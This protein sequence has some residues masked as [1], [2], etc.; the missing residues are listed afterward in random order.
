MALIQ[1]KNL[2]FG[3]EG[4]PEWVFDQASFQLDTNW[5]T[6]L[7]G[8]NGR[9]KTTPFTPVIRGVPP[10]RGDFLSSPNGILSFFGF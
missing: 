6:G 7:I 4:N 9:G 5:K 10:S 1:V 8:R 3:Y 2:T